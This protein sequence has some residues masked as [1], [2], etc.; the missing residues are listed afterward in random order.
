M[1]VQ[2]QVWN[3]LR[4][5]FLPEK[6]CAAIMGNIDRESDFDINARETGGDGFGLFQWSFDRKIAL[7]AYGTDFQHQ[8]DF[9]W[10][11]LTGE[12]TSTTGA[13]MQWQDKSGYITHDDFMKGNG[14]IDDLAAAFCVCWER[15]NAALAHVDQRQQ[16]A[17]QYFNQYTGTMGSAGDSANS[18][19]DVLNIEA[20][21]YE[22]VANSKQKKDYLYGRRYRITVSDSSGNGLDVSDLH[23][24][25]N[26]IKTMQMQPNQSQ[27][28][29]YNLSAA[30][31]NS[32]T[33]NGTRVTIE[34]GYEGSQF[35][36][37]FDGDI[38]QTIREKENGNSFK[39][40]II[41]LDSDR[42]L[43]FELANYSVVKGQTAREIVDHI[44]NKAE[45][46]VPLGSISDRLA[47][48]R[49]TR[50]KV[51]FGKASEYLR[52]IAKSYDL[53]FYMDNGELNLVHLNDMPT[54]EIFDLSPSSGLIGTPQQTDYGISGQ[55]LLNPQIKLN[56]LIHID[57]SLVRAKQIDI[58]NSNSAPAAVSSNIPT[59]ESGT[60]L[61]NARSAILAEAKN[62]CDNP[63]VGYVLGGTGENYGGIIGYDCSGFTQHCYATAGLTINRTSQDQWG[64]CKALGLTNI[65]LE[66]AI[67]GDLVFW[68]QG[69]NAYHVAI[70]AGNNSIYAASTD[71]KPLADQVLYE[72]LYGDYIIGRPQPLISADGGNLPSAN[73]N[74][75]TVNNAN[76]VFRGID[77]DAIYRVIQITYDG[78][79]RGNSWYLNFNTITQLGGTV[80]AI[81]N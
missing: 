26:I 22:V 7:E 15:A 18:N 62:L 65:S 2:D 41:A 75:S 59:T 35:G 23:C 45:N 58:S 11:E 1:S 49:L 71:S 28:V 40:T 70:Y 38:L 20:T 16:A 48:Q 43:N 36:L 25:F 51:M 6:S 32:I 8:M 66:A 78:D 60:G 47:S 39:L 72:P 67:P 3:Y 74:S 17:N 14:S 68:F 69:D 12:N 73:G 81:S 52:Q 42:A 21:N 79:T 24:T 50:G 53:Q 10:T 77:S 30:T 80:P 34:A 57:N 76:I 56:S 13:T 29:I 37:I 27:I 54:D 44:A 9:F 64:Q 55:C 4:S 19:S 5:K 46:P 33:M 61:N 63:N 31:E